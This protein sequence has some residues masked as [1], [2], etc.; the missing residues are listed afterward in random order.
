M[1]TPLDWSRLRSAALAVLLF[2]A[3]LGAE[4]AP[5]ASV[6]APSAALTA[7]PPAS[8]HTA[9][10]SASSAQE[11]APAGV[12]AAASNSALPVAPVA[13]P[14]L[15]SASP[16]PVPPPSPPVPPAPVAASTARSAPPSNAAAPPP[17]LPSAPGPHH[18]PSASAAPLANAEVLLGDA[19][20]FAIRVP[21]GNKTPEQ[22][23][24]AATTALAAAV[25]H[26]HE[27]D[28][29]Y[30]HRGDFAVVLAGQTPIVE[31]GLEDA[32]AAGASTVD[33]HAAS[34]VGALRSAI[35]SEHRQAALSKTVFSISLLV[36]LGL[37]A[38]YLVQKIG[39]FAE[40]ARSW[41]DANAEQAL[42]VRVRQIEVVSPGTV[43]ST[44]VVVLGLGKRVA[45]AG[46]FYAW[47]V[48]VLSL[49]EETRDYT[50]K[51]TGL[52]VTPLSQLMTRL[53]TGLPVLAVLVVAG[54]AVFV[55]VRF[56][57]LFFDSI[58]RR[59]NV[60]SWVTPDLAGPTSTLL[61]LGVV[62]AALVFLAPL[63]TGNTEGALTRTGVVV[64]VALGL[65]S[66]PLLASGML[67]A[68]VLFGRR[69]R[70]GQHV[71]IGAYGGRISSIG[72]LDLRL[73]D[74]ERAEVRIPHL[75][76]LRHPTRVI[77]VRPRF[78]V[79]VAVAPGVPHMDVQGVL[80]RVASRFSDDAR[81]ELV[82]ADAER[83]LFRVRF[84]SEQRNARSE[85][86]LA[87]VEALASARVPLGRLDRGANA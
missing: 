42:A 25:E 7:A 72:L 84:A 24:Q 69:L 37:I 36:F 9:A 13:E 61:R 10:P 27:N 21:R 64:L 48:V 41:I 34:V 12:Q 49:F 33:V 53:A 74:P 75:Y 67:G 54:A 30:E 60:V 5:A 22:R 6:G 83:T 66:T 43:R 76:A 17:A 82:S 44:A 59:E 8:S 14:P 65:A 81:V 3:P 56:L 1:R 16:A 68:I 58:E 38:F 85:V 26:V 2:A 18:A 4:P 35:E 86:Q 78:D 79:D 23:A 87:I 39:E 77:G 47:L 70:P 32:Q 11:I 15:V 29:R 20:V 55:L 50:Q 40:R 31:L 71:E 28:V 19:H 62:L 73:E 52:I 57:G 80:L 46:V 51:L 45:Q 63:V